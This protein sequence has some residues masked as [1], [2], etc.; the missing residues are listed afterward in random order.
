[1]LAGTREHFPPASATSRG[2]ILPCCYEC[3]GL[4]NTQSP[5]DF[6]KRSKLVKEKIRKRYSKVLETPS[7]S[8]DE[9][10]EMGYAMRTEIETW[11]KERRIVQSR[12]AWNAMS[13]LASIDHRND[14]AQFLADYGSTIE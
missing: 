12:L 1:M 9:L 5:F 10:M 8:S 14:F 7:W 6:E 4:A 2:V 3:N 13:Y 11:Q